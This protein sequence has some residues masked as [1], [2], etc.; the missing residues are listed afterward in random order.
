MT[1]SEPEPKPRRIFRL[2]PD[3]VDPDG[4]PHVITVMPWGKWRGVPLADVPNSYLEWA[5]CEADMVKNN[6][7]LFE[8]IKTRLM[9]DAYVEDYEP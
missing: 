3:G 2:H 4:A 1:P 8:S 5:L 7:N 6:P 9:L